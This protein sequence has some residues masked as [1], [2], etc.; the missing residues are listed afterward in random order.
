MAS[1][2]GNYLGYAAAGVAGTSAIVAQA[3]ST[4]APDVSGG[5]M[6]L[7]AGSIIAAA[8]PHL[9]TLANRFF[10]D[11]KDERATKALEVA[12]KLARANLRLE[13]LEKLAATAPALEATA[14]EIEVR[15][16]ESQEELADLRELIA[17]LITPVAEN[18]DDLRKVVEGWKT[19]QPPP[20]IQRT[21]GLGS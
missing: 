7:G 11:R 1:T 15:Y 13:E 4:T 18:Q 10:D 3:T 12:N 20:L 8:A 6:L 2:S 16:I 21:L 5:A 14:R 17:G 19:P 9:I